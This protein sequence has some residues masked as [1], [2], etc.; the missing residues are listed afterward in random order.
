MD[1]E[2]T[3]QSIALVLACYL[4]FMF[5]IPIMTDELV[6]RRKKESSP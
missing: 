2:G 5:E 4:R 6:L 3:K 1:F